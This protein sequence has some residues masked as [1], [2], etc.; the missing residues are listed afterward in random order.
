MTPRGGDY[1][2]HDEVDRNFENIKIKVPSFQ[3]RNDP[4]VYFKWDNNN[5][6]DR[7][8]SKETTGPSKGRDEMT[9]NNIVGL[10]SDS[11]VV[12][13]KKECD[14]DVVESNDRYDSYVLPELKD[15]GIELRGLLF[16]PKLKQRLLTSSLV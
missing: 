11:G 3:G 2:G 9:S 16:R 4:E 7:V 10:F 15:D 5:V 6:C 14:S 13:S 8:I 1:R 12:G